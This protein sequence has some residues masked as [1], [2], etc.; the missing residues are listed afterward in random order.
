MP[1][2]T[3][4][5]LIKQVFWSLH[6]TNL[7][8]LHPIKAFMLAVPKLIK[9]SYQV[10]HLQAF[11]EDSVFCIFF[12]SSEK[13]G[14]QKTPVRPVKS[15][16]SERQRAFRA[17]RGDV[18]GNWVLGETCGKSR[19]CSGNLHL[20]H[21]DW[22][23]PVMQFLRVLFM[24]S[25]IFRARQGGTACENREKPNKAAKASHRRRKMKRSKG[26]ARQLRRN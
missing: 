9:A 3:F 18:M 14:K 26:G 22:M 6:F 20:E 5:F 15:C 23:N 2:L 7:S 17:F 19:N 4:Q 16:T 25:K 8:P 12:F 11:A 24:W 13:K 1:F 21:I 10:T